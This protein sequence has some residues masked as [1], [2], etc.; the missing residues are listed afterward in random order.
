[1][2]IKVGQWVRSETNIYQVT[3]ICKCKHCEERGFNELEIKTKD[4]TDT[5]TQ[6]NTIYSSAEEILKVS[7]NVVDLIEVGDLV[8]LEGGMLGKHYVDVIANSSIERIKLF[9]SATTTK[10]LKV[11]TKEQLEESGSTIN[12]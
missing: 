4:G 1:M 10:I 7:D 5:I 11:W 2:E 9:I 12:E 8:K 6:D 3:G